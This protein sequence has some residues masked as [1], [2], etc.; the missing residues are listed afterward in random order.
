MLSIKDEF[1][2]FLNVVA[3]FLKSCFSLTSMVLPRTHYT[4]ERIIS[5]P[6][7]TV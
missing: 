7:Y 4:Q 5:D 3:F 2:I 6:F 1:N